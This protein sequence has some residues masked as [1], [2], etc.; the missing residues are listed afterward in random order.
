MK[1]CEQL[2]DCLTRHID[3][4]HNDLEAENFHNHLQGCLS[5]RLRHRDLRQMIRPRRGAECQTCEGFL[6]D[7]S[8]QAGRS[9]SPRIRLNSPRP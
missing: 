1:T 7:S 3:G 2:I 5:C 6:A 4:A 9:E 8:R